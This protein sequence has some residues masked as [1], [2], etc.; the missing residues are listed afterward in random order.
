M[1]I[2]KIL[3]INFNIEINHL[4][5]FTFLFRTSWFSELLDNIYIKYQTPLLNVIICT[6]AIVI[7][8]YISYR[9]Y[10]ARYQENTKHEMSFNR[11]V[12]R[13]CKKVEVTKNRII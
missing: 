12:E 9:F 5:Y 6:I 10:R 8:Y 7:T 13:L 2:I 1:N 4:F 11:N 3:S